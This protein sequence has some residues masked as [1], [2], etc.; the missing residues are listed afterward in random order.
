MELQSQGDIVHL[1][2]PVFLFLFLFFCTPGK[3][4]VFALTINYDTEN[5]CDTEKTQKSH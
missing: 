5:F 2:S 1:K 4:P 3:A